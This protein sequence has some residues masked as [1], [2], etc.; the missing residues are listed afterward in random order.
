[1]ESSFNSKIVLN[2]TVNYDAI[3]ITAYNTRPAMS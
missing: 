3:Q 2:A 1:V